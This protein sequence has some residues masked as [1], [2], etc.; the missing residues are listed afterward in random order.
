[1]YGSGKLTAE[2]V[3]S[4]NEKMVMK[5]SFGTSKTKDSLEWDDPLEFRIFAVVLWMLRQLTNIIQKSS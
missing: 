2:S 3:N 1:M 4:P 5:S